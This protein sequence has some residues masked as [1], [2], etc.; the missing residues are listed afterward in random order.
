ERAEVGGRGGLDE[1]A[2][3]KAQEGSAPRHVDALPEGAVDRGQEAEQEQRDGERAGGERGT[4][5]LAKQVADDEM[6]VLQRA[7]PAVTDSTSTP[8]SRCRTRRA[9]SAA[10]GS[11][12][13]ISTVFPWSRT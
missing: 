4:R 8:F 12:V 3:V 6:Q 1:R 2:G 10:S 9:R 7:P 5:L 13:T 11:W